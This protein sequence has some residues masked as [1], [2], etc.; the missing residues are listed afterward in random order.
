MP[1]V[2]GIDLFKR[3]GERWPQLTARMAF[4]TGAGFTPRVVEF[5]ASVPNPRLTKPVQAD[6]LL[7]LVQTMLHDV[8]GGVD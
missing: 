2:S 6:L 4:M 5:L 3:V 1:D 8:E 7:E